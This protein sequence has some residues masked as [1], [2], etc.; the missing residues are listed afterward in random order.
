MRNNTKNGFA[1]IIPLLRK[2]LVN[3]QQGFTLIRTRLSRNLVSVQQGFTLIE[4]LVVVSIIG[5]L[6]TLVAANLNSARQ[7]GRDTQ[8]KSDLRNIQTALRLYYQDCVA[9]PTN[10]TGGEI[11]GCGTCSAPAKCDWGTDSF[12]TATET[13]MSVLPKDPL[14]GQAYRYKVSA[15]RESYTLDACLENKSDDKGQTTDDSS[16]CELWMYRTQP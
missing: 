16:W 15:D 5:I 10:S 11:N 14:P 13:Y 9:F 1:L 4:M 7:R 3:I 8:R 2:K 12:E 6:T